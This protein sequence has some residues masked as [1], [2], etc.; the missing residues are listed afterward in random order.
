MEHPE[1]ERF[2]SIDALRGFALLGLLTMNF[3]TFSMPFSAY[4]NPLAYMPDASLNMTIFSLTHVFADQKFMGIFSLLFGASVLL[5]IQSAQRKGQTGAK[6]HYVRNIWLIVF[7]LLHAIF[8]WDGDILFIYGVCALFVYLFRHL[9]AILLLVLGVGIYLSSILYF[10]NGSE[11]IA[12]LDQNSFDW[13]MGYWAPN[14]EAIAKEIGIYQGSYLEQ[15]QNRLGTDESEENAGQDLFMLGLLLDGFSRS[16]GMMLI[17]MAA[18]K[19]GVLTGKKSERFYRIMSILGLVVGTPI[20]SLGLYMSWAN[21]FSATYGLFEGRIPNHIASL[22]MVA[23]YV[24]AIHLI[25]LKKQFVKLQ[26]HLAAVGKLALTNYL[27]QSVIGSVV[28][29]G[30]GLGLYGEVSRAQVFLIIPVVWLVQISFSVLWLRY[31]NY[32]P[33]EWV[34]RSLTYFRLASIRNVTVVPVKNLEK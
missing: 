5:V 1:K 25:V 23:G 32:G 15:L 30:W 20:V 7:G 8:L 26:S 29:Y 34:W 27:A 22:F 12:K 21:G 19:T 31:F 4:I 2:E 6:L 13:L 18:Y 14:S 11:A 16:F 24:G 33:V 9:P 28:F 3:L 17:G 10:V